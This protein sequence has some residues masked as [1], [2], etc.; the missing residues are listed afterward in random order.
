MGY[1]VGKQGVSSNPEKTRAITE[2][3]EP[4]NL[5]ELRRFMGMANQLGNFSPNL[6]ELS[7]PLHEVLS[8]KKAWVW[9]PA[10]EA[11]FK[12]GINQTHCV[13]LV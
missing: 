10:Q 5:K 7:Q 2:M 6:A 4:K 9:G 12:K 1:V 3:E 8:P 11:A 13:S